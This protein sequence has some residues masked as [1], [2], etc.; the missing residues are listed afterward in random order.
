MTYTF[1]DSAIAS[2]RLRIVADT[3]EAA[4]REVLARVKTHP[5]TRVLDLGCGPGHTTRM[6]ADMFQ[7]AQV[8]GIDASNAYVSEATANA[9]PRC[10]FERADVGAE[11]LSGA[12]ADVVYARYLL[13]HFADVA[14][15]VERW[16]G[17]LKPGGSL[18]LEEPESIRSTDPDFAR[19]EEIS[20]AL[21]QTAGG[22]VFYAGPHIASAPT[23]AEAV[24]EYDDTIAI[25]VNAGQ[26]A[27]MFWRN[28]RAWSPDA[29][30]RAGIDV[31]E[32]R[33]LAARLETREHDRTAG[34]FDWRQRQT[35]FTR[36]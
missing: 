2:E 30:Q 9:S 4:A 22:G 11:P 35:I 33:E 25:E 1:G 34:L 32:V 12:P 29:L 28:A 36:A 5:I 20:V 6:L 17:A 24:R 21:V 31:A 7:A 23:P 10:N 13:S 27:A 16:C 14:A 26:A 19:Y 8:T 15:Y 3:M 18:V